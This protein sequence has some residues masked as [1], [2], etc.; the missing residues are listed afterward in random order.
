VLL[1]VPLG[2]GLRLAGLG[3]ATVTVLGFAVSLLIEVTQAYVLTGRVANVFD[4]ATNT[5]GAALAAAVTS[6]WRR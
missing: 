3:V 1:F 5:L 2:L 4:L 6:K